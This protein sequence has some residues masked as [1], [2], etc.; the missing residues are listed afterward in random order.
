MKDCFLLHGHIAHT[1]Q[2]GAFSITENGYLVCESGLV[3]GVFTSVPEMYK[4]AEVRDYGDCLIIPGMCDTHLHAPQYAFRGLG[5]DME[6][7][8]WLNMHAFPEELKYSNEEYAHRAYSQF[9]E[10]L[11]ASATTRACIFATTDAQATLTLMRLIDK[12]GLKAYVGKVSMDRNAPD[13]LLD[14]K[15]QAGADA[16]EKWLSDA[17]GFERVKPILTPRFVPSCSDEML[18]GLGRLMRKYGLPLQSHLSENP[19]EVE[20]VKQLHPEAS[21][22]LDVY[23]RFGLLDGSAVM[24]HCVYPNDDERQILK[25]KD[26]LVSHCPAS[27]MNLASGIAPVRSYIAAGVRVSLGTD[28][29]GGYELSMLRAITDAVQVSKL[30]ARYSDM[31]EKPLSLSEAFYMATKGGGSMFG[32]VGS[33]E[34]GCEA[35]ALVLDDSDIRAT[36]KLSVSDR[37]ERAIYMEKDVRIRAKYVG[38]DR[39]EI[40]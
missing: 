16:F 29:A 19:S 4:G 25:D 10:A 21:S 26:V 35:D 8:E 20:W 22:Y 12:S 2:S 40:N 1:P 14:P 38:G 33:F 39:I 31:T 15:G 34:D 9:T 11:K 36:E 6:L 5:M 3:R 7:I 18:S 37:L 23:R 30:R 27:N 32:K 13:E 17:T 28:I 24:A